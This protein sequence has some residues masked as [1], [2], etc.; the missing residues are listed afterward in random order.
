MR[1]SVTGNTRSKAKPIQFK[2]AKVVLED[3]SEKPQPT[4]VNADVEHGPDA[5]KVLNFHFISFYVT[6]FAYITQTV[7]DKESKNSVGSSVISEEPDSELVRTHHAFYTKYLFDDVE[8]PTNRL[9]WLRRNNTI[10]ANSVNYI[11]QVIFKIRF[12]N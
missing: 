3:V 7:V 11:H 2:E 8:F 9:S 6:N 5:T 1:K 4:K 12:C 10:Q